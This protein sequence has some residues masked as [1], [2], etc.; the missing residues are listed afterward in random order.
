MQLCYVAWTSALPFGSE[1][2][3]MSLPRGSKKWWR[4]TRV[5]LNSEP[6]RT[7][8][9]ALQNDAGEWVRERRSKADLFQSVWRKRFELP[10]KTIDDGNEFQYNRCMTEFFVVRTRQVKKQLL[11]LKEDCATGPDRLSSRFLKKCANSLA[12]PIAIIIRVCYETGTWPKAWKHHW[13]LPI[14]I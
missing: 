8:I 5:L 1:K 3:I 13:M 2:Q 10:P 9:P 12:V 7:A 6:V 4:L 14:Y 11:R